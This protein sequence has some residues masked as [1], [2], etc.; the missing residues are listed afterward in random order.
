M[1]GSMIFVV[2][3]G[4]PALLGMGIG[5]FFGKTLAHHLLWAGVGAV[6]GAVV[7]FAGLMVLAYQLR[8]MC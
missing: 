7:G 4:G 1:I 5:A 2:I 6:I 8:G 3:I